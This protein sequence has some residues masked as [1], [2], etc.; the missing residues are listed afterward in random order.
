MLAKTVFA[1]NFLKL[2]TIVVPVTL[3]FSLLI[4][5]KCKKDQ[6]LI[7]GHCEKNVSLRLLDIAHFLNI[8]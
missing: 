3:C 1:S 5:K 7:V 8:L 4:N 6:G 2:Q